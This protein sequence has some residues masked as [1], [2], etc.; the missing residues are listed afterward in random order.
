MNIIK[1]FCPNFGSRDGNPIKYICVHI[2]AGTLSSMDNTFAN[3]TSEVSANYGIGLNGEIHQYV[4]D[5]KVAWANGG[6]LNP[7][8][9]IVKDNLW[10]NQNKISLSVENEGYDLGKAPESQLNALVELIRTLATKYGIPL[11]RTHIIGH[12]EVTTKKP[13]CPSFDNTILDKIVQRCQVVPPQ[14]SAK[15]LVLEI[16]ERVNKLKTLL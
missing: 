5:D 2:S 4:D 10:V 9:Q 12:R 14:S 3:P 11:D 7:T 13:T 15:Q 1:K 8:A 16:E 6:V